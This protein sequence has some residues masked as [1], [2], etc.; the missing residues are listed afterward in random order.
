M[1]PNGEIQ[2]LRVDIS[3]CSSRGGQSTVDPV[4]VVAADLAS[5]GSGQQWW[6][7]YLTSVPLTPPC[8]SVYE[9]CRLSVIH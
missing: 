9:G 1:S 4:E 3:E 6:G 2:F 7:T 5:L 8:L